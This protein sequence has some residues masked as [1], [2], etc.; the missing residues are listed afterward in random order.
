MRLSQ[1]TSSLTFRSIKLFL[2]GRWG[3]TTKYTRCATLGCTGHLLLFRIKKLSNRRNA[4]H[5]FIVL[6]QNPDFN[7]LFNLYAIIC[8]PP[9]K[10]CLRE[11][12]VWLYSSDIFW[13]V[14]CSWIQTSTKTHSG[15]RAE[16]CLI[17]ERMYDRSLKMGI[18]CS[19][20][21]VR[22]TLYQT[23]LCIA[24]LRGELIT[25]PAVEGAIFW[26]GM[27]SRNGRNFS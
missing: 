4:Y 1:L 6:L 3:S 23:A 19:L 20:G 14:F 11:K 8:C 12:Q 15:R 13:I 16:E 10:N 9:F 24:N 2:T 17:R 7:I 5:I 26:N 27:A 18:W 21:T 22:I 25:L